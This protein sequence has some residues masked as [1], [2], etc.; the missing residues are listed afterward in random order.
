VH[1]YFIAV[2]LYGPQQ[3]FPNSVLQLKFLHTNFPLQV[4]SPLPQPVYFLVTTGSVCSVTAVLLFVS[5][6]N[7]FLV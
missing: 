3:Y 4:Y 2:T 5:M 1:Q 6:Y 7:S